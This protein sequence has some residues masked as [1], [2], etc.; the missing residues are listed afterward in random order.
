MEKMEQGNMVSGA[1]SPNLMPAIPQSRRNRYRRSG[2]TCHAAIVFARV[3]YPVV[4]GTKSRR[5]C[6]V[7]EILLKW[8]E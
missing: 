5:K 4:V 8:R 2:L 3:E 1:T 6:C 7:M